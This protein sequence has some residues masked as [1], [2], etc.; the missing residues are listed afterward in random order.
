MSKKLYVGNL[1]FDTEESA[2]RKLFEGDGRQVSSVQIITDRQTG[3]SRGFGFV[4][5]DNDGDAQSAISSLNGA[6][7]GG[8]TLVVNEARERKSGNFRPRRG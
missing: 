8:R 2:L 5:F 4:E 7:M 3:R 1:P 6:E